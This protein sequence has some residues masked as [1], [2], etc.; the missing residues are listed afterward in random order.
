M[1]TSGAALKSRREGD[2]EQRARCLCQ[3][4]LNDRGHKEF[5]QPFIAVRAHDDEVGVVCP[6]LLWNNLSRV[7]RHN[8][9]LDRRARGHIWHD[10]FETLVQQRLDAI[11]VMR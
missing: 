9:T 7:P 5:F 3:D 4:S 1:P 8:E 11:Q 10:V 2:R 6:D